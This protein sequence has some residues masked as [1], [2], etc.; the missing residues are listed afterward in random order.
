MHWPHHRDVG[1]HVAAGVLH[2]RRRL[3]AL[4]VGSVAVCAVAVVWLNAVGSTS[5]PALST[6]DT[7]ASANRLTVHSVVARWEQWPETIQAFGNIVPWEEVIVSAQVEG[8]PLVELRAN[9]GDRVRKGEVLARFDDKMLRTEVSRLRAE[10]QQARAEVG[11][12]NAERERAL[13]LAD[14]GAVSQQ[15]VTQRVTAAQVAAARLSAA[16]AQLSARELDLQRADVA[17]P[18]DGTISAR[19]ALPGIVGTAGLELF[20]IIRRDK[21]EW[22]GEL[23]AA[24]LSR[25]APGQ[26]VLLSLPGGATALARIR[27]LAPSM[28][29]QTR[30]A[31]VYADIEQSQSARA[32][33]YVHGRIVLGKVPALVVSASAVVVRDGESFAFTLT[34]QG[35]G[36]RV[37]Q[38]RVE[39]GRRMGKQVE[40]LSGLGE[41][42]R[43][44]VQ[45]AGFLDDGDPVRVVSEA[46][47][48]LP[49]SIDLP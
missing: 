31:V 27:H 28:N 36:Q 17:A 15:E 26:Q 18:D 23:T 45:G 20:R 40:I 3:M 8:Q 4:I 2:A 47:E 25:A 14:S 5:E 29:T 42:D 43:V 21:L 16:Q 39:V 13:E 6:S 12:A 48:G 24:Q 30:L 11:Q 35:D 37:S 10:V 46:D 34:S 41:G 33:T 19:N 38:K 22:R 44:V 49:R 1:L 32:G 7:V 9:V